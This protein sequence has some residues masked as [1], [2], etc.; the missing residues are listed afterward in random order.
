MLFKSF[1]TSIKISFLA[2]AM[3]MASIGHSQYYVIAIKGKVFCIQK[4]L[5]EDT[6]VQLT[7]G[8]LQA[9]GKIILKAGAAV[10]LLNEQDDICKLTEG[11]YLLEKLTFN[12]HESKS[13]ISKIYNY[14]K[15]FFLEHKATESKNHYMN[16]VY[17]I[18]RGEKQ[19]PILDFPLDGNISMDFNKIPFAWTHSCDNCEYIF[20]INDLASK[21]IVF[22]SMTTEKEFSL[23]NPRKYLSE[24]RDYFWSVKLAGSEHSIEYDNRI[25][26]TSPYGELKKV[27]SL[28]DDKI[29]DVKLFENDGSAF[30]Y[31]LSSLESQGMINEAIL[32]GKHTT[33]DSMRI[34]N[35][36]LENFIYD[37]V[38]KN[39]LSF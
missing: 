38:A 13:S 12:S 28:I 21:E 29:K 5:N 26:H 16:K 7:Y 8:A 1:S 31:T 32:F 37:V 11:E 4:E 35:A 33:V 3:L 19:A 18:S 10:T 36:L 34:E 22:S 25:F 23:E 17:A 2:L 27:L 9:N 24:N 14:F 15:S 39:N 20:T 30:I 6:Y